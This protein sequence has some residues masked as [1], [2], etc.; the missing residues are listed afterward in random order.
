MNRTGVT[1]FVC[2]VTR[3]LVDVTTRMSNKIE[4]ILSLVLILVKCTLNSVEQSQKET[5]YQKE[6]TGK[7][8]NM[9]TNKSSDLLMYP[10]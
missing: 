8:M 4:V 2:V 6:Q 7:F 1:S 9:Q 5:E 10:S 3:Q